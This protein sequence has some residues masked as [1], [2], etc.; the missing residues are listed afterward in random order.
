MERRLANRS[1]APF[2]FSKNPKF[3]NPEPAEQP[4]AHRYGGSL[5]GFDTMQDFPTRE[6]N[7]L[8]GHLLP[9]DQDRLDCFFALEQLNRQFC[10][11]P[12]FQPNCH[13]KENPPD[14]CWYP[15]V[16]NWFQHGPG[17]FRVNRRRGFPIRAFEKSPNGSRNSWD[18]KR[19]ILGID[20]IL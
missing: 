6:R 1:I 4:R 2:P 3:Q 8:V 13:G 17:S 15:L 11:P 10:R 16:Q 20:R 7:D 18:H 12:E 5:Y 9:K 19:S 14:G